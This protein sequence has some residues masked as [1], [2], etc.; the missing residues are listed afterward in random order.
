MADRG[1][2][3]GEYEQHGVQGF[4]EQYGD[5]YRNPH[6]VAIRATLERAIA[7]WQFDLS[8]VL[9]LACGSGE[10]T[11]KVW[12]LGCTQVD[13]ID[14]YTG[15]AYLERTGRAAESFTFEQIASGALTARHYSLIVCSFA[16]HLVEE[17]RLPTLAYQLSLIADRLLI[18]TPHKRP[19][20]DARWG[21]ELAGEIVE[22]RVRARAYETR[23]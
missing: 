13:A 20:I 14:P 18:L 5:Q 15:A 2:I 4:Y 19:E 7:L 6:E 12:E 22:D 3:R 11:L 17:S 1:S 9:D 21:W 16:M 23:S 10:V 8:H